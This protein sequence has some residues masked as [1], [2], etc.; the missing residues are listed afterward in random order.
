MR[1][2]T[3]GVVSEG[4]T[5][6][7]VIINIIMKVI[8][9]EHRFLPLQPDMSETVGLGASKKL[10]YGWQGVL[11]WCESYAGRILDFMDDT[12][13][14]VLIIQIDADIAREPD[15]NCSKPC[16]QAEDTVLEIENIIKRNLR[17]DEFDKRII[18]CVPSDNTEA[19]ALTAFDENNL[20]HGNLKYI[21]CVHDPDEVLSKP[22]FNLIRRK[23]GKPKKNQIS[24]SER[25]IPTIVEK[26]DYIRTHCTQAEKLHQNLLQL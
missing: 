22:P 9:G 20:H 6:F 24:Y 23:D 10:S 5:D 17:I 3:F 12:K 18:C 19:W 15:I 26:W 13:V 1:P 21:E 4:P 14:D 16:P 11:T 25:L 7:N 8:P 2:L